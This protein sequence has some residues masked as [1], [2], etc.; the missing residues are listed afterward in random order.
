MW[1]DGKALAQLCD[2]FTDLFA[3]REAPERRELA[4]RLAAGMA[5]QV[6]GHYPEEMFSRVLNSTLP[7]CR[8]STARAWPPAKASTSS[9]PPQ[10]LRA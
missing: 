1:A 6:M 2:E 9:A 4:S 8:T 10:R 7:R 5:L 3:D